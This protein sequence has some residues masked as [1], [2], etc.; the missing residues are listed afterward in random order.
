MSDLQLIS[1]TQNI[2]YVLWG[3]VIFALVLLGI[4]VM[5]INKANESQKLNRYRSTKKGFSSLLNWSAICDDGVLVNKN[6]SYTASWVYVGPDDSM[7][8]NADR[9]LMSARLNQFFTSFD[10]GWT[11]HI[12]AIRFPVPKYFTQNSYFRDKVS[13]GIDT[14]RKNY[15]T[16]GG[17]MYDGMFVFTVTYMPPK[18]ATQKVAEAMYEK[19][20]TEKQSKEEKTKMSIEQFQSRCRMLEDN[21]SNIFGGQITRLKGQRT[22]LENGTF[23]I[24]DNQLSFLNFCLTGEWHKINLPNT[25]VYIDE[26]LAQ[27]FQPGVTPVIGK[28]FINVVAIDSLPGASSPGLFNFLANLTCEYR[29]NT[30]YIALDGNEAQAVVKKYRRGWAQ[31]QRGFFSQL[32]NLPTTHVNLDAVEMTEEADYA[33]SDVSR[34]A[35]TFG[36][37]TTNI[38]LMGTDYKELKENTNRLLKDLNNYGIKAR[39]ETFNAVDA[40]LG[41]L[42]GHCVENIRKPLVSSINV[43]DLMPVY[44]PWLGEMSAP[45]PFAGYLNGPALMM[46]STGNGN[47]PFALNLHVGDLGHTMIL[48]P[49]GAGKSTLLATLVAQFLRYRDMTVY[50]FDKGMSMYCLCKATG[51]AHY[52]PGGDNSDL[53]FAPLSNLESDSDRSWA[54]EWIQSIAMLN[55]IKV[56]PELANTIDNCLKTMMATKKQNPDYAMTLS[57]FTTQIQSEELRSVLYQY[58]SGGAVGTLVDAKSDSMGDINKAISV[59]EIEPL[60]NKPAKYSLPVLTYL[61]HCIE[62][63]LKGQPALIVLDEA[64]LMLGNPVFS[65]KIREWLKVLRKANC[66]VIMATQSLS[67]LQN[68]GIMDVLVESCPTKIFLPN[69]NA[70]QE[71]QFALYKKFGLN[72]AQINIIANG[73]KKRDYFF[74]NGHHSRLFQLNLQKFTLAFVAVSDKEAI[75]QINELMEK[76]GDDWVDF[77]L[78]KRGLDYPVENKE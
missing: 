68:S 64:W 26:L 54:N 37:Y 18:L 58:L 45:C 62:K 8:E 15:Y 46:C 47:T 9:N 4:F 28:K 75:Q 52:I 77:Y 27:D 31:K 63:N 33:L 41:S 7:L 3:V 35:I 23:R 74:Y 10:S 43:A 36:F 16:R 76:H 24:D 17:A 19:D 30:R 22:D 69:D 55:D 44:T 39:H 13:L 73:V 67:D 29:W 11:C 48:G 25:P 12:D 2:T 71:E 57:A 1:A 20:G 42:P 56:T 59:F 70:R 61:F 38:I 14:E 5:L 21:L 65:A 34:G 49:T 60:M 72:S 40:F 53:A 50:A 51:G 32:F 6:G 78:K 66:A